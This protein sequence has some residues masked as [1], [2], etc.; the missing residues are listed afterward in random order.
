[1]T[2]LAIGVLLA[3]G[4][5]LAHAPALALMGGML[6]GAGAEAKWGP[7]ARK[8]AEI[9]ANEGIVQPDREEP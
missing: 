8:L 4:G 9:R 5:Y 3:V 7:A 2:M 6:I 1:M